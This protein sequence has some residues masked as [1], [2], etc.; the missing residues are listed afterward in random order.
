MTWQ[1]RSEVCFD[2]LEMIEKNEQ[3]HLCIRLLKSLKDWYEDC[4]GHTMII[5]IYDEVLKQLSEITLLRHRIQ[6]PEK[7]NEDGTLKGAS[8]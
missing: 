8:K 6:Y 7:W 5:P 4:D 2:A 3:T 1:P